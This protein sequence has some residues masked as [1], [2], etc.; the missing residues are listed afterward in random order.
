MCDDH[1]SAHWQPPAGVAAPPRIS[2]RLLL[3]SGAAVGALVALGRPA[4]AA[5]AVI[6]RADWGGDLPPTGPLDEEAPGDVRFLLV[7]HT[8]S[9]NGYAADAVRSQLRG[10]YRFHTGEKGWPDVAYNFFVDRFGGVWEG[11]TGSLDRPMKASATG[12]SQGYALL[13]CFLGDHSTQPPTE[14]AWTAMTTLLATLADRYGIDTTPGATTTFTSRGSN[15]WPVG[16]TVTTTTIAGHRDMSQTTCPGDAA[17]AVVVRDLPAWVTAARGG[18]PDAAAPSTAS[19]DPITPEPEPEPEPAPSTPHAP[20][21][22]ADG[23]VQAPPVEQATVPPPATVPTNVATPS[24]VSTAPVTDVITP[25]A[26]VLPTVSPTESASTLARPRPG[27]VLARGTGAAPGGS[28]PVS[29]GAAWPRVAAGSAAVV[30]AG[31]LTAVVY[32]RRRPVAA[33]AGWSAGQS[34]SAPAV[35]RPIRRDPELVWRRVI[36]QQGAAFSRR[37]SGAFT[38]TVENEHIVF[39]DVDRALSRADIADAVRRLPFATPFDVARAGVPLPTHVFALLMD[40]RI[41]GG[42]W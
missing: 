35:P 7:H 5:G 41:R 31:A 25:S 38:Y 28:I 23:S 39:S 22:I 15:R 1:V 34:A 42:D 19:D 30:T 29:S 37:S 24:P 32:L 11:R 10:I 36:A 33:E 21:T 26:S 2:R 6:P 4:A 9:A 20:P 14:A 17:Y 40:S 27:E 13:C 8:A 16:A 12:G 3:G 18:R